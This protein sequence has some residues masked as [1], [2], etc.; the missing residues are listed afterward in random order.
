MLTVLPITQ[1]GHAPRR[2]LLLLSSKVG[3]AVCAVNSIRLRKLM[4]F[5]KRIFV[6]LSL[7]KTVSSSTLYYNKT[8]NFEV[9]F[10]LGIFATL[11]GIIINVNYVFFYYL[12]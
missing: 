10:R 12:H 6:D 8:L 3:K 5:M 2:L 11:I 1:H 7:M 4:I 9:K